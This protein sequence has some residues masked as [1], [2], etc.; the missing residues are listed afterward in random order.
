MPLCVGIILAV[1]AAQAQKNGHHAKEVDDDTALALNDASDDVPSSTPNITPSFVEGKTSIDLLP[2]EQSL[3]ILE[4]PI[5]TISFYRTGGSGS[6]AFTTTSDLDTTLAKLEGRV[7]AVVQANP[8]LGGWLVRGKGIGSFD[9]T[10]RLWYDP[11]GKEAAPTIFQKMTHDQVPLDRDTDFI[12]YE[13]ILRKTS[14]LVKYNAEIVNRKEEPLFRITVIPGPDDAIVNQDDKKDI[15][16]TIN[17]NNNN[18]NH[19]NAK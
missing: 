8:W 7:Q 18:N 5:S 13:T 14:A 16:I 17:N 12:E 10:P 9:N 4:H 6:A 19:H 11:T 15:E 3:T 2:L 1:A